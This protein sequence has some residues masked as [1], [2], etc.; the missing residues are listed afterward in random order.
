MSSCTPNCADPRATWLE[1]WPPALAALSF[2][3]VGV[4]LDEAEL[5]ALG[6]ANG[7]GA[8][9]FRP[10]PAG[11]LEGLRARLDAALARLGSPAFVRLGSRSPKDT[12]LFVQTG[13]GAR[14]GAEVLAQLSAGSQRIAFDLRLC[15]RA[16]WPASVFL[17]QWQDMAPE[18]EWR[19]FLH[20]G[21]VVGLA[22]AWPGARTGPG[23][24]LPPQVDATLRCLGAQVSGAFGPGP[25]VFDAWLQ[26]PG[27]ARLIEL[28][29]WGPPTDA[30]GFDWA[31]LQAGSAAG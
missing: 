17:R 4:L 14:S 20:E 21:Q 28:N 2:P 1:H 12:A 6:R 19:G 16:G 3:Q 30:V 27:Q 24:P 15:L 31:A 13:G 10:T 8:G 29:P 18:D 26:G 9:V 23:Q 25:V 5:H 22:P 11:V 7:I